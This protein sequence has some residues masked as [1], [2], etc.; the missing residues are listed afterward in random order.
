M[1]L[2]DHGSRNSGRIFALTKVRAFIELE[3][4]RRACLYVGRRF[5]DICMPDAVTVLDEL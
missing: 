2:V 5:I 4:L 3:G 1:K